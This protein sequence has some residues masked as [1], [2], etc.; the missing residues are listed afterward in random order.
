MATPGFLLSNMDLKQRDVL[1]YQ[2]EAT[3]AAYMM[4]VDVVFINNCNYLLV[5][6]TK[7]CLMLGYMS[8]VSL[9]LL[10]LVNTQICHV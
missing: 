3:P 8:R 7:C 6:Q 4:F 1:S 9:M 5:Q 2:V 10:E